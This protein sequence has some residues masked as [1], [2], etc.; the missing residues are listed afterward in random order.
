M[1]KQLVMKNK[2]VKAR[3][4][5]RLMAFLVDIILLNFIVAAPFRGLLSAIMP[6][7]DFNQVF[8]ALTSNPDLVHQFNLIYIIIGVL[9]FIYFTLSE[10]K[11]QQSLG[12]MLFGLY[13]VG[14]EKRPSLLQV[15][16]R[17]IF[18]IPVFPFILLIIID[19]ILLM[20]T[21]RRL[22]DIIAKTDVVEYERRIY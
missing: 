15:A 22:S 12:K 17:N 21:H 18:L 20:F 8:N 13:V 3:A 11:L 7:G 5:K 2:L 10:F 19:P 4:L 16:I 9:A 14:I 6:E 1:A